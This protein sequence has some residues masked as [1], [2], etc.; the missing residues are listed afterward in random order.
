MK[1]EYKIKIFRPLSHIVDISG[2]VY[3]YIFGM[4]VSINCQILEQ[5]VIGDNQYS[6]RYRID[7]DDVSTPGKS[8]I[9]KAWGSFPQYKDSWTLIDTK[10]DYRS[11]IDVYTGY[12][13]F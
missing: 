4:A 7:R 2:H 8:E 11:C 9:R 13:A 1:N 6:Y 10:L 12:S 5:Y 3:R